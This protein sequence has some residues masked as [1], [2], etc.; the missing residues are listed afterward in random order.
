MKHITKLVVAF[1]VATLLLVGPASAHVRTASTSLK[2]TA[3]PTTVHQGKTVTFTATLKSNWKKCYSQ[4]RV[5]LYKEGVK[6][7]YKGTN[8]SGVAKFKV[9]PNK[10]AHYYVK[11]K[12]RKWGTHPHK[13]TCLASQ[14]KTIKIVVKK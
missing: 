6:Q 7:F 14:S 4:R 8:T 2:L 5:V 10:T 9:Q 11:F 12:G 3:S 13:H 1:A